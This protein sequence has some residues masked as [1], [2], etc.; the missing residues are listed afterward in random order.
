MSNKK[1]EYKLKYAVLPSD[2]K[3]K[4]AVKYSL[5]TEFEI[6]GF[7]IKRGIYKLKRDNTC[8]YDIFLKKLDKDGKKPENTKAQIDAIL[9]LLAQDLPP[10][11]DK[12]KLLKKVNDEYEIRI[13]E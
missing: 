8:F 3:D 12:F 13:A 4:A 11:R 1:R 10:P 6:D 7:N 2:G 9:L 5:E